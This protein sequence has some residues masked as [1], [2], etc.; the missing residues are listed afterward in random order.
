MKKGKHGRL[1]N[2]KIRAV[3]F[4]FFSISD[5]RPRKHDSKKAVTI[6]LNHTVEGVP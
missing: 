3:I 4:S 6:R 5:E 1:E 2:K